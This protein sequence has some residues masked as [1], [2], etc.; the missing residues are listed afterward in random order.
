VEKSTKV[1]QAVT[2]QRDYE[3]GLVGVYKRY[4][5]VCEKDVNSMSHNR[6]LMIQI[7]ASLTDATPLSTVALKCLCDL[8]QEKSQFNFSINIMDII[9]KQ[10]GKADWDEVHPFLLF[11]LQPKLCLQSSKACLQTIIHLFEHD[12][13]GSDS[14]H[15]VRLLSRTIKARSFQVHPALIG[16]FLFLRLSSDLKGIRA[17]GDRISREGNIQKRR[18]LNKKQAELRKPHLSKKAKKAM[19]DK[20]EVEKEFAEAEMTVSAEEKQKEVGHHISSGF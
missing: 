4:L 3:T 12:I 9:V 16:S 13:I 5:E 14:L 15:L 20:R 18:P 6:T 11:L 1:S 19:K 10:V 7:D 2:R 8:L 17:S